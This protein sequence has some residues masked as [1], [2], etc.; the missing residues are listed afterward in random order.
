MT[1]DLRSPVE[2]TLAQAEERF[3]ATIEALCAAE[4]VLL[5]TER[6]V[7]LEPVN[8]D[9]NLVSLVETL[10]AER[11]LSHRQMVSGAGHDA[12]MFAAITP[13]C[14]IFVP[15]IGGISH[16]VQEATEE[17]DLI[18]GCQLLSDVVLRLAD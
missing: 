7:R 2:A 17:A 11:G 5:E 9:P 3:M 12:Q 8:F 6:L 4:N 10:A 1:I 18:A 15:S 14:M 13:S 16:N